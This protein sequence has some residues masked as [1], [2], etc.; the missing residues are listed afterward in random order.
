MMSGS[1]LE[2]GNASSSGDSIRLLDNASNIVDTV[3]Y[4][5]NNSDGFEDDTGAVT[6]SVAPEPAS[7]ES[8]GRLPDGSDTDACGVDFVAFTTPTPGSDN[9]AGGG[10]AR[11]FLCVLQQ[12]DP[13]LAAVFASPDAV[14]RCP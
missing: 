4:G 7:G 14:L 2:M 5:P 12:Y 13:R 8:V 11:H 3:I 6:S 1:T 10:L 9:G